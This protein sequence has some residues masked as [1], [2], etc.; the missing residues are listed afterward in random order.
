MQNFPFNQSGNEPQRRRVAKTVEPDRFCE[1][2]Q[3]W[4]AENPGVDGVKLRIFGTKKLGRGKAAKDKSRLLLLL[5]WMPTDDES[6]DPWW[7]EDFIVDHPRAE[8]RLNFDEKYAVEAAVPNQGH[9]I[10]R[11]YLDFS[12]SDSKKRTVG[13]S[14]DDFSSQLMTVFQKG[15]VRQIEDQMSATTGFSPSRRRNKQGDGPDPSSL[16]RLDNG[17]LA[18]AE[19]LKQLYER[20]DEDVRRIEEELRKIREAKEEKKPESP[21]GPLAMKVV[22]TLLDIGGDWARHKFMPGTVG[23]RDDDDELDDDTDPDEIMSYL[24]QMSGGDADDSDDEVPVPAKASW[25]PPTTGSSP[26]QPAWGHQQQVPPP[27]PFKT[28][29]GPPAAAPHDLYDSPLSNMPGSASPPG[30]QRPSN[31]VHD[32][33]GGSTV[34]GGPVA[35]IQRMGPAPLH[36]RLRPVAGS[37]AKEIDSLFKQYGWSGVMTRWQAFKKDCKQGALDVFGPECN[38]QGI[39]RTELLV[40][41]N[42]PSS[43]TDTFMRALPE[44]K[45]AEWG[46]LVLPQVKE[47]MLEVIEETDWEAYLAEHLD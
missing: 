27:Q 37:M 4:L 41:L 28:V 16:V 30:H 29:A 38:A 12:P 23:S 11:C 46:S 25:P 10:S 24:R 1:D 26:Q 2:V 39:P 43:F 44:A 5:D 8:E 13:G 31:P 35:S 19:T 40:E 32:M 7:V 21:F 45:K 18:D 34:S 33:F 6:G 17:M 3:T 47:I 9:V 15:M 42:N 22:G 20:K 36:E 14:V